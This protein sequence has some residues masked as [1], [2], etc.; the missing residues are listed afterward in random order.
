M[1]RT[2]KPQVLVGVARRKGDV[3]K[4]WTYGMTDVPACL[5]L[6][7]W[8]PSPTGWPRELGPASEG[9]GHSGLWAHIQTET[10][11]SFL[12]CHRTQPALLFSQLLPVPSGCHEVWLPL[13]S[14]D[15]NPAVAPETLASCG[16]FL[17]SVPRTSGTQE[18]ITD[19]QPPPFLRDRRCCHW[20]T[21]GVLLLP[22][23]FYFIF[24]WKKD[25][26][27]IT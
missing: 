26:K 2:P 4:G 20:P 3:C 22:W 25:G 21:A 9:P 10:G 17:P 1:K 11:P 5:N 6:S 14:P 18:W 19:Y 15:K 7:C 27:T 16:L 24:E 23:A 12:L 8:H 13:A